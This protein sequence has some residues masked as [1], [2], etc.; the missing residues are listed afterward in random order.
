MLET[1]PEE[2]LRLN[3]DSTFVDIG[4][5]F[6]KVVFHAKLHSRVKQ[7]VGIEYVKNRHDVAEETLNFYRTQS[8]LYAEGISWCNH[9]YT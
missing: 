3:K 6:G 7:S 1:L 4:S 9:D 5:G 8:L 2:E